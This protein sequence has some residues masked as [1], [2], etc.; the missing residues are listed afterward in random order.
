MSGIGRSSP[1]NI[2]LV[3][4]SSLG[5]VIHNLPVASD[6][7]AHFPDVCMDWVVEEGFAQIP[8]LHPG[9][10]EIIPVALRRWKQHVLSPAT[11]R[12]IA[13]FR[14][15]LQAVD[16]D[17]VLD[18]QGLIK[19]ALIS[20]QAR[21]LRMG[22]DTAS[23]R[24]PL[25]ARFYQETFPVPKTLHAVERNRR[26]AAAAFGYTPVPEADYGIVRQE[27]EN[28]SLSAVLLTASS[29]DDKLWPEDC[30]VALGQTLS[31]RG[32]TLLLPGGSLRERERAR[33]LAARIPGAQA[34]PPMA[35]AA[36]A[37][38]FSHARLVVGVDTGL[39]HL[40]AAVHT[41]TVALYVATDP[42]LTGVWSQGW[43]RNLGGRGQ[44]PTVEAVLEQLSP[45]L[46]SG[47]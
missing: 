11:W 16:Y 21:G 35:L 1:R 33:R 18:T 4:T 17:A 47:A 23:A 38:L 6:L 10:R 5:D 19:S 45:L 9:V 24:E 14:Q 29:R 22:Y 31:K 43:H 27:K 8:R 15:R 42:G 36:L 34:I 40:A 37:E 44:T 3:K 25:A 12:E 28:A 20:G 2:L 13:T 41:P 46:P 26:L 30:W 32:L 39:S 7:R